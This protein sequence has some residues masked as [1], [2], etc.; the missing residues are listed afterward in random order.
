MLA[1]LL[2]KKYEFQH[3]FTKY[4]VKFYR[5]ANFYNF[6]HSE[7]KLSNIILYSKLL[8][9]TKSVKMMHSNKMIFVNGVSVHDLNTIVMVGDAIQLLVSAWFYTYSKWLLL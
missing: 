1:D 8:P 7:F 4:L 3:Q 6:S 5:K 2:N 9:D